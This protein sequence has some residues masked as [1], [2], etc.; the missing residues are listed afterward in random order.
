MDNETIQR[1]LVL[2]GLISDDDVTPDTV[3]YDISSND[4]D[5][6]IIDDTPTDHSDIDMDQIR[7]AITNAIQS[8]V[9]E[10]ILSHLDITID[11]DLLDCCETAEFDYRTNPAKPDGEDGEI[12]AY[13]TLG[14][15]KLD[16]KYTP[17]RQSDNPLTGKS[18]QD[19][20]NEI[21]KE[22]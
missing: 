7:D 6:V 10:E 15:A 9:P 19:I 1:L 4:D 14:Q 11:V 8:A 3:T 5:D 20:Y 12:D 16:T 22:K 13:R 21:S 2:S 18:F 17:A